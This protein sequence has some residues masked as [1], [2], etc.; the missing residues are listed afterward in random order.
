MSRKESGGRSF[1]MT[2]EKPLAKAGRM[3]SSKTW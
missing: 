2:K 3:L 1:W